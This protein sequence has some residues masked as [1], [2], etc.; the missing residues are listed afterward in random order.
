MESD[1]ARVLSPPAKRVVLS[2]MSFEYS[3]LRKHGPDAEG[4]STPLQGDR[5]GSIPTVS[6]IY[7]CI[8]M[9]RMLVSK[10][11][12]GSSNLSTRAKMLL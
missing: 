4:R 9:A 2:G 12:D 8:S 6:T 1:T 10:T 3:A 7:G 5:L 11:S